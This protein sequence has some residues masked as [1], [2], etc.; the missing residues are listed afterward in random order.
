MSVLVFGSLN[1]DTTFEVG[2]LPAPGE[3]VPA[4]G[5]RDGHGG[6]GANQAVAARRLGA[7]VAMAGAVGPD[8]AGA[9]LRD[10]LAAEGIDVEGVRTD[11]A[12]TGQALIAVDAS[13]E[14]TIIVSAGANGSLTG[15][16]ADDAAA[17][18][19]AG[20][21]LVLQLESPVPAV[22]AVARAA[23]D[24]SATVLL[25]AAPPDPCTPDLVA[26]ADV[27]VCNATEIAAVGVLL[28]LPPDA[29]RAACVAASL[30]AGAGRVVVTLG[31]DGA[32]VTDAAGTVSVA[33]Y[34]V[35]AV[36]TVGAGDCFVGA[37]AAAL[38]AGEDLAPAAR[39]ASAAAAL[40]VQ[41]P[42]AQEAMPTLGEVLEFEATHGAG[43]GE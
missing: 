41:R 4:T 26:L 27:L 32:T 34:P 28:G 23:R 24:R 6:K 19:H 30:A 43:A 38:A 12:P 25:N 35:P 29:D 36:D 1:L 22:A 14:N 20:D 15:H 11:A 8:A 40:A 2:H 16:D 33:A 31:R 13:G 39:R 42:G 17:T 37:L 5:R 18:L 7:S 10:A 21:V 3:T 9:A